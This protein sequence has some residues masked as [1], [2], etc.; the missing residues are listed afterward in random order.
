MQITSTFTVAAHELQTVFAHFEQICD[1]LLPLHLLIW[2]CRRFLLSALTVLVVATYAVLFDWRVFIGP[3]QFVRKL[4]N[5]MPS[6]TSCFGDFIIY[7]PCTYSLQVQGVVEHLNWPS[8][9]SSF[10]CSLY[11]LC[12]LVDNID[13]ILCSVVK[14]DCFWFSLVIWTNRDRGMHIA[15][16]NHIFVALTPLSSQICVI[17]LE[18]LCC[19]GL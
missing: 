14:L 6:W 2:Q 5:E 8:P 13:A 9:L 18:E 12:Y 19:V 3:S 4:K 16:N 10:H 11:F 15:E 1:V 17:M 7:D